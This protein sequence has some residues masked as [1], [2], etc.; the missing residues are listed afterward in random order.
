VVL[1]PHRNRLQPHPY[2]KAPGRNAMTP[3]AAPK[4]TSPGSSMTAKST[5]FDPGRLCSADHSSRLPKSPSTFS[6]A[7]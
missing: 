4:M 3:S 6:A 5:V 7:C 2:P 1:R